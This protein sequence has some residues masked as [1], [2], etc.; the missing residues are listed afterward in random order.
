MHNPYFESPILT[1]MFCIGLCPSF[2]SKSKEGNPEP[3]KPRDATYLDVKSVISRWH[4]IAVNP[5]LMQKQDPKLVFNTAVNQY[6]AINGILLRAIRKV[7][8]VLNDSSVQLVFNIGFSKRT[9]ET[10]F[11]SG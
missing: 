10:S 1:L 9:V 5:A 4:T 2:S 11:G 3:V 6:P 8:V 7:F